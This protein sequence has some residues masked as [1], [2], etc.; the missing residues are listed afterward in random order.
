[1]DKFLES[2][3]SDGT[4]ASSIGFAQMLVCVLAAV[5]LGFLTSFVYMKTN[6]KKGYIQSYVNTLII[7]PSVI[8]IVILLIGNNLAQAFSL[9]GVFTLVRFRSIAGDPGDITY[10]FF[11][12]AVGLACGMGYIAYAFIFFVIMAAIVIALNAFDFGKAKTTHMTLKITIPENLDYNGVFDEVLNR[13]TTC[14]NLRRVK[15]TEFGSLFDLV[16]NVSVRND[17][18]QKKFID[19]LR[20]LNGNLSVNLVLAPNADKLYDK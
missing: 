6:E 15:T 1:M 16:Y 17:I 11:T 2:V 19:D 13:N 4:A 18:D 12:V 5:I 7:L 20:T 3:L 14:W 8:S 9:A 10:I